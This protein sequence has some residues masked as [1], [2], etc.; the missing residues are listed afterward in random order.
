MK[1]IING[2]LYDTDKA[3]ELGSWASTWDVRDFHHVIETLYVK[4]TG[5]YFLHGVGGPASKYARSVGQNSWSG[6]EKIIPLT[7]KAAKEWAEEHLSADEYEAIWGLPDEDAEDVAL[8]ISIPAR[9]MAQ[10]RQA[11]AEQSKSITEY[12]VEQLGKA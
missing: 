10:I 8:N 7:V 11:A 6:D 9:L 3:R 2:K 5:E 4:R 1:K 12:V